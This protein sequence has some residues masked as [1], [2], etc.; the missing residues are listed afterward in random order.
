[1]HRAVLLDLSGFSGQ[2]FRCSSVAFHL[3]GFG[4]AKGIR[5]K[6]SQNLLQVS[7]LMGVKVQDS[8]CQRSLCEGELSCIHRSRRS[9]L[10]FRRIVFLSVSSRMLSMSVRM[11]GGTV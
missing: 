10:I 1:M 2:A 3:T 9:S 7:L 4:E 11:F 6:I 5:R 8:S